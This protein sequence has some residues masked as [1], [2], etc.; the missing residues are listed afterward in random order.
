M[1]YDSPSI[2]RYLE[3]LIG[4]VFTTRFADCHFNENLFPPLGGEKSVLEKRREITWNASVMSHF[5]PRTNQSELE[6]QRI[7]HLQNLANQLP[8]AFANTK[9]VTK[10]H[11][12]VANTP[13]RIDVPE[14]QLENESQK[15][16]KCGRLFGSK[17]TT[18]RKRRTLRHNANIEHNAYAK[19][20]VEQGT[21]EEVHNKEVALEK[22]QVPK[23]SE[24]SI[25]YVHKGDKWDRNNTVINN[26]FAFQV[27]LD[28]IRNDEDPEPQNVE[29]C[30]NKNDWPKWKE[31]M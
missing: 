7:I 16:L 5:D 30:R 3:P 23:N 12:P 25:S 20:Y 10:S 8:D 27:A 26:I 18:S 9:K 4:D 14:G 22:A 19:T 21:S 29:E 15:R 13:A 2:I 17:D 31:A 6:V 28:I 1:G 11:V 24:I